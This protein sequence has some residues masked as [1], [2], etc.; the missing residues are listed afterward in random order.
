M[1]IAYVKQKLSDVFSE[2]FYS[3]IPQLAQYNALT[4]CIAGGYPPQTRICQ[5]QTDYFCTMFF[6]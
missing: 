4:R 2:S 5:L 3:L 1:A 6:T